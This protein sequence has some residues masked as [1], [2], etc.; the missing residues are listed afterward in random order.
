MKVVKQLEEKAAHRLD[1]T[2]VMQQVADYEADKAVLQRKVVVLEQRLAEDVATA[3]DAQS[4]RTSLVGVQ[5]ERDTLEMEKAESAAEARAATARNV[6]L[7]AELA[8]ASAKRA[9]VQE[10]LDNAEERLT[11]V[12]GLLGEE[13][14]AKSATVSEVAAAQTELDEVTAA[15]A[16]Q[17]K[18]DA[19]AAAKLA[20]DIVDLETHIEQQRASVK[21][22][23]EKGEQTAAKH[24]AA[25]AA[26]TTRA[27]DL[28]AEVTAASSR[29]K[30]VEAERD[31]LV[32]K[33][34]DA[35]LNFDATSTKKQGAV[36]AD[37]QAL[38]DQVE[39]S[40]TVAA[41]ERIKVEKLSVQRTDLQ[42]ELAEL[43]ADV[44]K[45]DAEQQVRDSSCC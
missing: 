14:R 26:A 21:R 1:P 41:Q 30:K 17:R 15:A 18:K 9:Q 8:S 13:R 23:S 24:A 3:E 44:S 33:L 40:E 12:S 20:S 19:A 29:A 32:Q 5:R 7:Q 34:A 2:V 10:E 45:K 36:A 16:Q 22:L 25:Q 31:A 6:A 35:E 43:R 4:S 42:K 27:S 28:E 37:L 39:L 38:K 11:V